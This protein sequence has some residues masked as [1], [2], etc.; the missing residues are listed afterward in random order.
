M[1][2]AGPNKLLTAVHGVNGHL[3][4]HH[5]VTVKPYGSSVWCEGTDSVS[6]K[7]HRQ[8]ALLRMINLDR[9]QKAELSH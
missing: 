7:A 9:K 6:F 1:G 3:A 8:R 2:T 5:R 4:G